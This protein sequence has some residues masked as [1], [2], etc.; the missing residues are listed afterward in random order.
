MS[1]LYKYQMSKI[2][3]R[4]FDLHEAFLLD[5]CVDYHRTNLNWW[6]KGLLLASCVSLLIGCFGKVSSQSNTV[7]PSPL[8]T[9]WM[10]VMES[11]SAPGFLFS[12]LLLEHFFKIFPKDWVLCRLWGFILCD[13]G[14]LYV[15]KSEAV[16]SGLFVECWNDNCY[17]QTSILSLITQFDQSAR[18]SLLDILPQFHL[19]HSRWVAIQYSWF[20]LK[21]GL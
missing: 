21:Q 6:W 17:F 9:K 5:L 3:I 8:F 2:L 11:S 13:R 7:L 12:V 10:V 18:I 14:L 19:R 15:F 16:L 4:S 1:R 20:L